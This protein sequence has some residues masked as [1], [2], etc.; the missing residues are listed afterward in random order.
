MRILL[1]THSFNSLAQRLFVELE[2]AGHKVSVEFDIND[3]VTRR[4]SAF[5]ARLF[6]APFLKRAIPEF[7]W[8]APSRFIVH[9][10]ISDDRGPSAL[11]WAIVKGVPPLGGHRVAGRARNGR[12]A[13][14]GHGGL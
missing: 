6:V 3:A 13:G 1:L 12:G 10:G 4:R 9:P 7:V 14:V 5:R 8:R 2:A 11:D